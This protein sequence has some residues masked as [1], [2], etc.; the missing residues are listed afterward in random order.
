MSQFFMAIEPFN[1]GELSLSELKTETLSQLASDAVDLFAEA[2]ASN[3]KSKRDWSWLVFKFF[4]HKM[5]LIY[6]ISF[7]EPLL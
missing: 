5:L 2:N 4:S 6:Y 3:N 7:L 1:E